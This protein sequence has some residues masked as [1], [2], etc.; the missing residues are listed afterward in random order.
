V[1]LP[2]STPMSDLR[3]FMEFTAAMMHEMNKEKIPSYPYTSLYDFVLDRGIAFES[4]APSREQSRWLRNAIKA[5]NGMGWEFRQRYCFANAMMLITCDP[6]GRLVHHEGFAVGSAGIP[7]HHAWVVLDEKIV[8][9]L[10][11]RPRVIGK[12]HHQHQEYIG[13]PFADRR[14]VVQR[15]MVGEDLSFIDD[16][17]NGFP[18]LQQP[19]IGAEPFRAPA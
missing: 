14:A 7:V 15:F 4:S 6:T 5:A 3:R 13:V 19:R 8:V 16:P 18:L 11:W 10:T 1:K 9:D 17:H 12:F 2:E